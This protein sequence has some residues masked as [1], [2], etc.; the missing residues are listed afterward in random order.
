MKEMPTR[1]EKEYFEVFDE[2]HNNNYVT[3]EEWQTISLEKRETVAKM[4]NQIIRDALLEKKYSGG[5]PNECIK[6]RQRW[7]NKRGVLAG[8]HLL[9]EDTKK[10]DVLYGAV[11]SIRNKLEK[12]A[13]DKVDLAIQ[14]AQEKI[15]VANNQYE[16]IKRE[17]FTT[18]KTLDAV[19]VENRVF[20]DENKGMIVDLRN[21]EKK[22]ASLETQ[23]KNLESSKTELLRKEEIHYKEMLVAKKKTIDLLEEQ[24]KKQ[25]EDYKNDISDIKEKAED[26]RHKLI[27]EVQAKKDVNQ[28]LTVSLHK[29]EISE[30]KYKHQEETLQKRLT[31]LKKV[32]DELNREYKQQVK[33]AFV[34]EK[35]NVAIKSTNAALQQKVVDL[36]DDKK[37][38]NKELLQSKKDIGFLTAG[39]KEKERIIQNFKSHKKAQSSKK[40]EE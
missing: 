40:K 5:S 29:L 1:R 27:V 15:T 28:K 7:L 20:R 11:E 24:T 2:L 21:L 17:L 38:L 16:E 4:T 8:N 10:N 26:Q 30:Q 12:Q 33:Q 6:Y 37:Q 34:T 23:L 39:L 3:H 22:N 13:Q 18:K 31:Q 36:Q 19:L 35:E 32:Y 25:Q 9:A 14:A